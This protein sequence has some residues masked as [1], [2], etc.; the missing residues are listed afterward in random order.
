MVC[1]SYMP[2]G[3]T[4]CAIVDPRRDIDA[5]AQAAMHMG[6]KITHALERHWHADIVLGHMDLAQKTGAKIYAHASA[7]CRFK[8]RALREWDSFRLEDVQIKVL[9][10]PG[11]TPEHISYVIADQEPRGEPLSW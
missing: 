6:M 2:G 7:K 11:R 8:H 5:Y 3:S 10:T 9:A 1:S 4:T